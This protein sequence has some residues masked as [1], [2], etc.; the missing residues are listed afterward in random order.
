MTKRTRKSQLRSKPLNA[1]YR[2]RCNGWV[3]RDR[4]A[5]AMRGY[6]ADSCDSCNRV[7]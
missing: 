5:S 4:S 2:C 3:I 7:Q 6:R 1:L